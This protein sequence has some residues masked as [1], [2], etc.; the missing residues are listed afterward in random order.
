MIKKYIF[1]FSTVYIIL[2]ILL[3]ILLN[4]I[5][6]PNTTIA[7]V[8]IMAAA[9]FT[10]QSFVKEQSR[11]PDT[12][13]KNQLVW[14]CLISTI[15]IGSLLSV[16]PLIVSADIDSLNNVLRNVLDVIPLWLLILS[17]FIA[18]LIQ[19]LILKFSFGYFANKIVKNMK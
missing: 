2:S 13:E 9:I 7:I 4:F 6:L 11:A 16:I 5:D 3:L 1:I 14:G 8:S 19:Y 18:I 17:I 10:V 12:S 15:A